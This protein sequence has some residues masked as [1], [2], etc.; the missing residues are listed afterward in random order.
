MIERESR[1]RV[2]KPSARPRP[3]LPPRL[4][5]VRHRERKGCAPLLHGLAH[6]QRCFLIRLAAFVAVDRTAKV[7]PLGLIEIDAEHMTEAI[8]SLGR[9]TRPERQPHSPGLSSHC[10]VPAE[11]PSKPRRVRSAPRT[12]PAQLLGDRA[13]STFV[14]MVGETAR[15]ANHVL[16]TAPVFGID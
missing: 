15:R 5:V 4:D 12:P 16:M 14:K 9:C 6:N 13:G 1:H 8:Y 11:R 7:D 10:C 3:A 2:G